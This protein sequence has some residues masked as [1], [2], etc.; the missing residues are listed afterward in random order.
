[1]STQPNPER[2]IIATFKIVSS[3]ARADAT[4]CICFVDGSVADR[5]VD[6]N[7]LDEG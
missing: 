4:I 5:I 3:I 7:C 1:V 6:L 2:G